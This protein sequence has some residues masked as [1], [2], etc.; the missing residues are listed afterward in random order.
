MNQASDP[1]TGGSIYS[2]GG[3]DGAAMVGGWNSIYNTIVW[4]SGLYYDMMLAGS[5]VVH[6]MQ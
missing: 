4:E 6:C 2:S 5:L 3:A 1:S